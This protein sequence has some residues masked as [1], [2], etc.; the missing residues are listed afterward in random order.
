MDSLR[1]GTPRGIEDAV[2]AQ[3]LSEAAAGP[4]G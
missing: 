1:A 2:D 4:I 3:M